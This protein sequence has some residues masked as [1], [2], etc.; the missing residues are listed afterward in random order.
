M[1][2]YNLTKDK[3]DEFNYNLEGKH[4]EFNTLSLKTNKQLWL[5]DLK[6]LEPK[7]SHFKIVKKFKF[8]VKSFN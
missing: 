6:Q 4:L 2:I 3:I 8:K 5:D 7:L 1:P